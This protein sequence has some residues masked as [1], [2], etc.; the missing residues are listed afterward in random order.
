MGQATS[1]RRSYT[2]GNSDNS[3]KA[4]NSSVA[5]SSRANGDSKASGVANGSIEVRN[6]GGHDSSQIEADDTTSPTSPT[7]DTSTG[8]KENKRKRFRVS[9]LFSLKRTP[10][11]KWPRRRK[12][13]SSASVNGTRPV[14]CPEPHGEAPQVASSGR[15]QSLFLEELEIHED[16]SKI[17][18]VDLSDHEQDGKSKPKAGKYTKMVNPNQRPVNIQAKM[19]LRLPQKSK[20]GEVLRN[21]PLLKRKSRRK[22]ILKRR[23]RTSPSK[24]PRRV[25]Q[26][27]R[28]LAGL[29]RMLQVLQKQR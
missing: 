3:D 22:R 17:E 24:R 28:P 4:A 25:V 5:K 8:R 10:S 6:S 9:G 7:P 12:T 2:P 18:T 27:T 16:D 23:K 29:R 26:K 15:P 1:K 11:G 21:S 14:S 20:A 19:R 13:T